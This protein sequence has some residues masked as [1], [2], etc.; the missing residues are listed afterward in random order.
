M[1][2]SAGT[3]LGPYEIQS[4]L[5]AGGMGEVYR[6]RDTRLERTVAIKV[7]PQHLSSS[8]E[9]RQRFEREAKTI[10][11]LS[12]PHICALHDV[13]REGDTEYL[14]MEYLEGETLAERLAKGALPLEQTLR[15]GIQIAGAL[16]KAHLHGIVH[17]DLKPGNVMITR[18]GVKL[19]DFGLAKALAPAS[20]MTDLTALPTQAAPVTREGTLLGTFQY[21]SPEQLE[22]KEADART[23]IFALGCVLYEMATGKKAFSGATQASVISSIMKEEPA[24]ISRVQPMSP[25]AF[26]RL[27]KGCLA[28]DPDDR[29]QSARDVALQLETIAADRSGEVTST[30]PARRRAAW[31]PWALA[32]IAVALAAVAVLRGSRPRASP[33]TIR[34]TVPPPSGGAFTYSVESTFLAVSPDGTELAYVAFDSGGNRRIFLRPL[35][36]LEARPIAGTEGAGSVFYSP[37]GK[38]IGFFAGDRLKRVELGGGAPVTICEVPPGVGHSGTWGRGGDI[39]FASVQGEAIQRVATS[40]GSP[41]KVV[42]PDRSRGAARAFWPSYLPDGKRYL[43]LLRYVDGRGE[44][45]IGEPGKPARSVTAMQSRT[46]YVDPGYLVFAREGALLAQR[47]DPK[48]GRV[49]GE[50]FSLAEHVRYLISAFSASFAASPA[51]T[52]AYQSGESRQRLAWFDRTGRE[53]ATVGIPGIYQRLAVSRDARRILFDR[54]ETQLGT[55]DIWSLDLG[56]ATETPITSTMETESFPVWLPDGNVA[57]SVVRG[58]PP[59][60]VRRNL[61]TGR[62]EDILPSGKFQIAQDVS[63]DGKTLLFTERGENGVFDLYTIPLAGGKPTPFVVSPVGKEEARFSPDGNFV[64]LTSR[65]SG[66]SEI[67]VTA[68]PGPGERI[69]ISTGGAANPRW[70]PNGRELFYASHDDRLMSVP[71]RTRPSLEL[72]S[73]ASVFP[74]AGKWGWLSFEVAPDGGRFL[75]VVPEVVGDE[76]PLTVVANWTAELPK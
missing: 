37:D 76:L 42:Q 24:P 60:L 52:I 74:I 71:V 63:P 1:S 2:L 54:R 13:G 51:G 36:A 30:I 4:L 31:A 14:V 39:L 15:F 50:P 6:A 12:H 29:W 47:F 9:V 66:R 55:F 73:P 34:F 26:D 38:S 57:Y 61:A 64:A 62:E 18:S 11:Q 7:L 53:L 17:R 22:G 20:P 46:Q 69:R 70:N 72:G 10:S 16:D 27:V 40:G 68:Y 56:R 75:A 48:S 58:S 23:D 49:T 3:R 21:M 65:E 59:H 33:A 45:M 25:P 43:Y 41:E 32:A 19:L 8:P 5:G 28:K 35:S 44:L 67:Y